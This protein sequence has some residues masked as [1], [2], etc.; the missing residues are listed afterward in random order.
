MTRPSFKGVIRV[1]PQTSKGP[2]HLSGPLFIE[3]SADQS[4][5]NVGT[6]VAP[7]KSANAA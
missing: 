7:S 1:S 3:T 2:E 5:N 4:V 6:D